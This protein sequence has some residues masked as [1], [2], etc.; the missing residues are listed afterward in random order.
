MNRRWVLSCLPCALAVSAAA[1]AAEGGV[2]FDC[3]DPAGHV[4]RLQA[5]P[6]ASDALRCEALPA[7]GAPPPQMPAPQPRARAWLAPWPAL[8][9]AAMR[10]P[11]EAQ[12]PE[13]GTPSP[14]VPRAPAPEPF[15][16]LIREAAA[17]YEHD[18]N[19][20]KAMVQVES[21]FDAQAVSPR[22]AIGLMQVMPATARDL[23]IAQPSRELFEPAR[24]V[25]AGAR[26]LRRLMDSFDGRPDLA[27][28]AYNAGPGA[29]ARS[30]NQVPPY[31]ET[32]AYVEKVRAHFIR[33]RQRPGMAAGEHGTSAP[34]I[35]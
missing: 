32:R 9:A 30:G 29:V 6:Q 35:R 21:G 12:R 33:L 26:L 2:V 25:D 34:R 4:Y 22:G 19:L 1:F 18:P 24:N 7:P 11:L 20:L 16:A 13:A 3:R 27:L 23:G 31:P 5:P 10:L 17:R 8:L 14:P 15:D 28:A